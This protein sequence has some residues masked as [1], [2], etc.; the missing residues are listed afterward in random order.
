M[1]TADDFQ[2]PS[3]ALS[4]MEGDRRERGGVSSYE[5][6]MVENNKNSSIIQIVKYVI[7]PA[8]F[9]QRSWKYILIN[10]GY[11]TV[12]LTLIGFIL[13]VWR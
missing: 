12:Y 4:P 9:E 3:P 7:L 8:L 10:V 2:S 11:I 13:G 5:K 1:S 6:L